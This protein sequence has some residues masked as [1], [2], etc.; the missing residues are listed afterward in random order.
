MRLIH[1]SRRPKI[2]STKTREPQLGWLRGFRISGRC[3]V[4]LGAATRQRGSQGEYGPGRT[5]DQRSLRA[6][7]IGG[8]T[9]PDQLENWNV[10]IK[11]RLTYMN[12]TARANCSRSRRSNGV[13]VVSPPG[14]V[15]GKP[16]H[17]RH[18]RL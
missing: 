2:H 13:V 5:P 3:R 7:P 9:G 18:I 11:S 8:P 6:G 10:T 14:A 1:H 17:E 16:T 4:V 12:L 15:C